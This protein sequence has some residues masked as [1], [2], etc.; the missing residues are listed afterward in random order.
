MGGRE[1]AFGAQE[2]YVAMV[3]L[4]HAI[5]D[6]IP[7]REA[8][9]ESAFAQAKPIIAASPGCKYA[10]LSRCLERTGCYLLIVDWERLP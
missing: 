8:E 5:L 1:A 9:F 7:G 2:R 10:S 3:I 4:E 6:V